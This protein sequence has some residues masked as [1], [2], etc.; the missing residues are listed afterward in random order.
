[1][2]GYAHPEVLVDTEWVSDHMSDPAVRL[3][4]VGFDMEAYDSGHAPGAV[5]WSWQRDFQH[6]VRRDIPDKAGAEALFSRSGI[7]NATTVVFYGE[8]N[9]SYATFAF[10]LLKIYGHK[11]ARILNGSRKK[12]VDE[13]R[14]MTTE[15][16]PVTPTT[17]VAREP[18]GSIRA[19]RDLVLESIGRADRILVDARSPEEY[20]GQLLAG[21]SFPN[22][23]AQRGGHIPGAVNIPWNL[24]HKE[25]GTFK[26]AEE[27]HALYSGVGITPDKEALIYCV[28]G[29][30]SNQT[31]FVLT[32]LLGYPKVRLYDGSWAEWGILMGVPI[33]K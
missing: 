20:R 32:Q 5:G 29:G 11:D 15:R 4:E 24:A 33:E 28:I 6:P 2:T 25:D 19:L 18:D 26:P 7:G 23:G 30:R 27:L 22:E 3:V 12:Y 1:M 10:W 13:G 9:N 21:W 31:W 16:P 8:N 17:Y 14:P